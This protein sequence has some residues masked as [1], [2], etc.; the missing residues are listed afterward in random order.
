MGSLELQFQEDMLK[1]FRE[2]KKIGYTPLLFLQMIGD[3]GGLGTAQ[4][5]LATQTPSEGFTKLWGLKRLDLTVEAL[6]IDNKER[7]KN[8][9]LS[10]L[11]LFISYCEPW[12]AIS[13]LQV[14]NQISNLQ[15]QG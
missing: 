3:Y 2:A 9:K 14:P 7:Y 6:I 5:L 10:L 13:F 11:L 12:T 15:Q 4:R 8:L 1:I